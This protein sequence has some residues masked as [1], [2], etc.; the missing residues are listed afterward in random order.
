[1]SISETNPIKCATQLKHRW[2]LLC[3]MTVMTVMKPKMMAAVI[4]NCV[5]LIDENICTKFSCTVQ[6]KNNRVIKNRNRKLLRVTSFNVRQKWRLGF[7][8]PGSFCKTGFSVLGKAKTGFRFRFRFWKSH[9]C[10]HC[11]SVG[12][13]RSKRRRRPHSVLSW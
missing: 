5:K 1:V 3:Q 13:G 12:R 8:K 11:E 2:R 9:N 6:H 4:L 7:P 10:V